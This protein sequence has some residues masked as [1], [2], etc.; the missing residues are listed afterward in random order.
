MPWFGGRLTQKKQVDAA[1]KVLGNLFEKTTEGG[2]DAP[3]VLRFDLSDSRFRYFVFCLSTVQMACA[4]KMTNPDS[5]LNELMHTVITGTV[6][7]D[8]QYFF[9]GPV[10]PQSAANQGAAYLQ[11]YLARWSAYV[12]IARGG[13]YDAANSL[14]CSML[15]STEFTQPLSDGDAQRLQPLASWI[16][17][18]LNAMGNAFESMAK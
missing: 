16:Q 18:Q 9:G 7:T 15:R 12:D 5:V 4:R 10:S 17:K 11:E 13:N 6:A 2:A 1:F 3:L 14:V 8:S